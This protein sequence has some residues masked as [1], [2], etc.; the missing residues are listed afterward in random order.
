MSG[1]RFIDWNDLGE[2]IPAFL[3][4]SLMP[5]TFS[6]ADGM[7]AGLIAHAVVKVAQRNQQGLRSSLLLAGIAT[8]YFLLTTLQS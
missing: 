2:A 8:A 5:L 4:I 7:A 3:V 1:I 6:V